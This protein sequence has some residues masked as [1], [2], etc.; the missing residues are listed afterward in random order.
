MSTDNRDRATLD[1]LLVEY[2][3][4]KNEQVRR[5]GFRD[6][7]LFTVL[8]AVGAVGS[9]AMSDKDHL[10]ALLVVPWICIVLGWTYVINDKAVSAIGSYIRNE[11]ASLLTADS[12]VDNRK[13]LGWELQ[14]RIDNTRRLRKIL[15]LIVDQLTFVA[16]PVTAIIVFVITSS[17][18]S[19]PTGVLLAVEASLLLGLGVIIWIYSDL[20]SGT[21]ISSA[22]EIRISS[23]KMMGKT[24]CA[25]PRTDT[26]STP[27]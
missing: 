23:V 2:A 19:V 3:Q 8:L 17:T 7:M 13:V 6:N 24:E 25:Q 11:L 10:Y 16:A 27:R 21:G 18:L 4:L 20:S 15:Q 9:Y 1:I 5:I 12:T 26:P 14:H 22:A